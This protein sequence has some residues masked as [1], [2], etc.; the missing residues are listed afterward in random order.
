MSFTD[1]KL[2]AL[3]DILK[4]YDFSNGFT[5][6]CTKN[7]RTDSGMSSEHI[8]DLDGVELLYNQRLSNEGNLA[9][10]PIVFDYF[11][12]VLDKLMSINNVSFSGKCEQF[13][14]INRGDVEIDFLENNVFK[15]ALAIRN[16][17]IHNDLVVNESDG[18]LELP[19]G[20]KYQLSDVSLLNRLVFNV[21]YKCLN[22]GKYSMYEKCSALAM[23]R[24]VFGDI[25]CNIIDAKYRNGELIMTKVCA[26][27]YTDLSESSISSDTVLFNLLKEN[28]E[29]KQGDGKVSTFTEG[30]YNNRTFQFNYN[31]KTI[32][33]PAELLNFNK[34][35]KLADVEHWHV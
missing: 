2:K 27:H 7:K 13:E 35:L 1:E 26:R 5:F 33:I 11:D 30:I 4:R 23:Y 14:Q 25:Q 24:K 8:I 34:N 31:N 9:I 6:Y 19:C 20:M 17:Y 29:H 21:A 16:K 12:A 32:I 10:F 22:N 18:Y 15:K 3:S 28:I